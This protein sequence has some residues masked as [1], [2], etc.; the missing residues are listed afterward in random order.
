MIKR[1]ICLGLSLIMVFSMTANIFAAGPEIPEGW[2]YW[3]RNQL[4]EA[5]VWLEENPLREVLDEAYKVGDISQQSITNV[6]SVID[7]GSFLSSG[8]NF[9]SGSLSLVN[10]TVNFL[11][12]I[13]VL[14]TPGSDTTQDIYKT[15]LDI[16]ERVDEIN[17]KVNTINETLADQFALTQYNFNIS[18]YGTYQLA[19]SNFFTQGG[20]APTMDALF[21]E[22]QSQMNVEL[23]AYAKQW[24]RSCDFG[25][26]ALYNGD[27][28]PLL[29]YSSE[30]MDGAGNELPLVPGASD[31]SVLKDVP[32]NCAVEN[33]IT[34]PGAYVNVP[35][36]KLNADNCID[37]LYNAILDGVRRAVSDK[38]LIV[39]RDGFY[40]DYESK[41]AKDREA[42]CVK[43]ADD[44]INSLSYDVS[45]SVAN[46]SRSGVNGTF[47]S[48]VK[49]AYEV[50]CNTMTGGINITSPM[51]A[52]FQCL[53]LTHGFEGEIR[54]DYSQVTAYLL[55]LTAQYFSFTSLVTSL[56]DS[57]ES[58]KKATVHSGYAK[59]MEAIGGYYDQYLTG[60]NNYCYPLKCAVE[61][62][63]VTF[64]A[65][66][67]LYFYSRDTR[68]IDDKHHQDMGN[69]SLLDDTVSYPA[70]TDE[71]YDQA[72]AENEELLKGKMLTT[73]DMALLYYYYIKQAEAINS[74]GDFL[75]Y[76]RANDA[77]LLTNADD[78]TDAHSTQLIT[79]NY[80]VKDLKFDEG[81]TLT[82]HVEDDLA[83]ANNEKVCEKILIYK[84]NENV[85]MN[86]KAY[87]DG[88]DDWTG[89]ERQRDKIVGD[90]FDVSGVSTGVTGANNNVASRILTDHVYTARYYSHPQYEWG[91]Y[92]DGTVIKARGEEYEYFDICFAENYAFTD[93]DFHS[94]VDQLKDN[95]FGPITSTIEKHMGA[96]V[97]V[98]AGNLTI[99]AN[100]EK[101]DK[102]T[103]KSTHVEKLTITSSKTE[104]A[105]DAFDGFGSV[106]SRILLKTPADMKVQALA[107][108]WNGGYFG[109]TVITL[110]SGNSSKQTKQYVAAY[111]EATEDI[112]CMFKAEN[113]MY[114]AGWDRVSVEIGVSTL[115]AKWADHIHEPEYFSKEPTCTEEGYT[116]YAVCK[117]CEAQLSRPVVL[118]VTGHNY[119][120]SGINGKNIGKCSRCGEELTFTVGEFGAF[121]VAVSG[122]PIGDAVKYA[123]G[124]LT[125]MN[126]AIVV[127]RNKSVNT[128]TTD[129][130]TV[131][132][133]VSANITLDGV[134]IKSSGTA[135]AF[136]IADDSNGQVTVTLSDG[137]VNKLISEKCAGLQKNGE[138]GTLTI[139][140]TGALTAIGG[141]DNGAGI[142]S[143]NGKIA[144]NITISSGNIYA[145]ATDG[146]SA[147][148]GASWAP[149]L[150]MKTLNKA[151]I[152]VKGG[153][154]T[155][156]T[157]CPAEA[158]IYADKGIGG[159]AIGGSSGTLTVKGGCV[160][161]YPT[162]GVTNM[163]TLSLYHIC[164]YTTASVYTE[165][166]PI[167]NRIMSEKNQDVSCHEIDVGVDVFDSERNRAVTKIT[168][169]D[170]VLP[171]VNH[172]E[173][174]TNG[175]LI[176]KDHIYLYGMAGDLNVKIER[177]ASVLSSI[178]G[179]G[180]LWLI[181]GGGVVVLA[182]VTAAVIAAKRK[183]ESDAKA[184]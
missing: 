97:Q 168:R 155:A 80:T 75:D 25:I 148:I 134:N 164:I 46:S 1:L 4:A 5:I 55:A 163:F 112:K 139:N 52:A 49:S 144:A 113:N 119:S 20:S 57:M 94:G 182:G 132:D 82:A 178:F 77:L 45:H 96:L 149:F 11:R 66:H 127:I 150:G 145:E 111:G 171:F 15:V 115:T 89:Y 152:T 30:N 32:Y 16:R 27:P 100:V 157:N 165:E 40:K 114:F 61:Y 7:I 176:P 43:I 99:G 156:K 31:E 104:F 68:H 24:Q 147:G 53:S 6:Q 161:A 160:T 173:V 50:Y 33:Y 73:R 120:L 162:I 177:N 88:Y 133:G 37:E 8:M 9:I 12:L 121:R 41:S 81:V 128:P 174:G 28:E 93:G 180:N 137:S 142:G 123:S 151:I 118:P 29:L 21:A 56:D 48:R 109:N 179:G 23:L 72:V 3:R 71:K 138:K 18:Q 175:N 58:S 63:D 42:L 17:N 76:L 39:S 69:W 78:T 130:I 59:T 90:L 35:N 117:T 65:D 141:N 47:A 108:K 158:G 107:N 22:Y 86:K 38:E 10:G 62:H 51:T 95:Q 102:G 143:S 2:E 64:K 79:S 91:G 110:A 103:V 170:Y 54:S 184:Q 166:A 159:S 19:W 153:N 172:M 26:R 116:T 98:P 60:N 125:V 87:N 146:L 122:S 106:S 67:T 101:V 136:G 84:E 167:L 74:S 70:E 135:P 44:L 183:K 140:G 126:D 124:V 13:G 154:V 92:K 169:D 105:P 83:I 85:L 129:V 131:A 181:I 34:L 14:K 36:I